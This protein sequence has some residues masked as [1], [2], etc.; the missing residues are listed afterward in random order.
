MQ[1]H[2]WTLSTKRHL[3]WVYPISLADAGT[4]RL[5][6]PKRCRADLW[7]LTGTIYWVLQIISNL[8]RMMEREV[9]EWT[10][11]HLFSRISKLVKN[12]FTWSTQIQIAPAII[13]PEPEPLSPAKNASKI[14]PSTHEK[15]IVFLPTGVLWKTSHMTKNMAIKMKMSLNMWYRRCCSKKPGSKNL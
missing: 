3:L 10:S 12:Q 8:M 5:F 9:L 15:A 13:P 14:I 11:F 6:L 1:L 4:T 7:S 2:I